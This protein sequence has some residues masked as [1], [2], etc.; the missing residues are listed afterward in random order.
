[1]AQRFATRLYV[2]GFVWAVAAGG[3]YIFATWPPEVRAVMWQWPAVPLT[4]LTAVAPGLPLLWLLLRRRVLLGRLEATLLM[5]A[6]VG[7]LAINAVSRQIVQ[8]VE[9][10]RWFDVFAQPTAP[11]WG[12]MVLFLVLFVLGLLLVVW[13]LFQVVRAVKTAGVS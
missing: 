6:Q 9:V 5:V 2:V 1:M 3:H 4:L 12:A 8:N 13:M 11:Q 7:V 10:G